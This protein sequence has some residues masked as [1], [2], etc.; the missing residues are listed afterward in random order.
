MLATVP[1]VTVRVKPTIRSSFAR[2]TSGKDTIS[3][4][5]CFV[6][7]WPQL[8]V[9]A[10]NSTARVNGAISSQLRFI[11]LHPPRGLWSDPLRARH[12]GRNPLALTERRIPHL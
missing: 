12:G 8:R 11:D 2:C 3:G 5:S 4:V 10:I 9:Q 7:R 6:A 1:I